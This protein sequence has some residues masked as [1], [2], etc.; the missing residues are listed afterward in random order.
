M[1]Y[2]NLLILSVLLI[3][4]IFVSGC[5][6]ESPIE[7]EKVVFSLGKIT[8]TNELEVR[9]L[10][11][12]ET[13]IVCSTET[14][15]VLIPITI[16]NKQNKWLKVQTTPGIT[17][18][19]DDEMNRYNEEMFIRT[20]EGTYAVKQISLIAKEE[21]IPHIVPPGSTELEKFVFT[22]P[23]DRE[24]KKLSLAYGIFASKEAEAEDWFETE[25]EIPS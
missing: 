16:E 22:I 2:Q 10:F 20:K 6:Q 7:E 19:F 11:T 18:L 24:P 15:F 4:V 9:E 23:Q 13:K 25:M 14:K 8:I 17:G 12:N 1:K 21:A 3:A 5:I